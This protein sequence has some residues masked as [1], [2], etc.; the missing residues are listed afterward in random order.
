MHGDGSGAERDFAICGGAWLRRALD[1][2]SSSLR[3]LPM[4]GEEA[5]PVVPKGWV[6]KDHHYSR[7][8][9]VD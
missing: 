2:T 7:S 4:E 9:L 8:R 6:V 1:W 5:D 3:P